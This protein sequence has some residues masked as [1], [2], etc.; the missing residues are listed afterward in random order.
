MDDFVLFLLCLIIFWAHFALKETMGKIER[1]VFAIVGFSFLSFF[2]NRILVQEEFLHVGASI[3]YCVRIAE[4]FI[5]FYIGALSIQFFKTSSV[6]TFFFIW[7][8]VLMVLQK[9]DLIGQFALGSYLE[10]ASGRVVGIASFPSEAGMLLDLVFCYLVFSKRVKNRFLQLPA[11]VSQ[12]FTQTY[13]YWLFLICS[14]LVIIT[15]SRIAI[16]AL[17]VTFLCRI[18]QDLKNGSIGTWLY[19][20]GF[21]AAGAVL[22]VVM[23]QNTESVA[24]RSAGLLSFKNLQIIEVVWNN[25]DLS[26][27]PIGQEAVKYDAYD[28]SWWLR[29]HKWI[30]AFKIYYLHPECW[31]QGIGPGFAMA[32]LDGGWLRLLTEYGLIGL[33][34]FI[35]LFTEI[36]RQSA[37]LKWMII[38]FA[39]NMIFFDVYLAYKPMSLL[40][41]VS[42]STWAQEDALSLSILRCSWPRRPSSYPS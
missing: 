5:F 30:Y 23:I 12:F 6:I 20:F 10:S 33:A 41:F 11:D 17:V 40:F 26:Y 25:I 9:G 35:R 42:G 31:L 27:D 21:V 34:L 1:L 39:I 19:G 14:T 7:N 8:A 16:I 15:G 29:I 28:L 32:A 13:V 36:G 3:F 24:V 38:A 22:T 2:I 37:P 4:Y 18:R